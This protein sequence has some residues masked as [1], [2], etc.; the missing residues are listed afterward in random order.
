[1]AC[2]GL[3]PRV[4]IFSIINDEQ[5]RVLIGR[6]LSTL[7]KGHWG[8]PGGHLEQGEDFFHCVERETLEETGLRIRATKVVGL[9]NDI[10]PE[11]NKH[12][13][14]VFTTCER[15]DPCQQ[16]QRLEIEKCEGWVWKTWQEIES[17]AKGECGNE[18]LFLPVRNLVR[19]NPQLRASLDS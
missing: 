19:E 17:M 1:M 2:S 18:E 11:L 4:G 13:V 6:R 7:G 10:F 5:G 16:P 9:T 8:F 15:V 14:T 12:Y 3:H